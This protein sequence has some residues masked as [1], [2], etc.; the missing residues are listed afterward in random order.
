VC[1]AGRLKSRERVTGEGR[2]KENEQEKDNKKAKRE[3]R[4]EGVSE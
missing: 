1:L 2:E 4:M 3:G